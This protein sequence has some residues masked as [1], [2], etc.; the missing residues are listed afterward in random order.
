L[1][2]DRMAGYFR[3]NERRWVIQSHIREMIEFRQINLVKPFS[4]LGGFDVILCRNVLIYFDNNTRARMVNQL[5]DMLSEGGI[6][7]LGATENLYAITDKF[8]SVHYGRTLLYRK[9]PEEPD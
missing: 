7:L 4:S 5:Y 9:P 1:S 6:L 3:K 2:A 8:E